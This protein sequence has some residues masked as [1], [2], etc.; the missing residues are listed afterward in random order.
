MQKLLLL[1]TLVAVLLANSSCTPPVK[2]QDEIITTSLG[3]NGGQDVDMLKGDKSR[4]DYQTILSRWNNLDEIQVMMPITAI[5]DLEN[6]IAQLCTDYSGGC[7]QEQ[8]QAVNV[9]ISKLK[10]LIDSAEFAHDRH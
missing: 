3:I 8:K 9:T 6:E 1:A 7:S 2:I 10:M 4:V 5:E